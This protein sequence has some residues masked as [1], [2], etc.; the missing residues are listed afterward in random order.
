MLVTTTLF[1]RSETLG[2]F[3]NTFR[4]LFELSRCLS[5]M[6][7]LPPTSYIRMIDIWLIVGQLL[8]FLEVALL[9]V[10]ETILDDTA[11]INHHGFGRFKVLDFLV[12]IV[13]K[14][15]YKMTRS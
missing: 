8:P 2:I 5:V 7:K 9:T 6:E 3:K 13:N 10:K 4:K 11:T 1:V 15:K 14:S 12:V